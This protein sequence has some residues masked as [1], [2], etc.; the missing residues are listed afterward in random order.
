VEEDFIIAKSIIDRVFP[1]DFGIIDVGS[2][3]G[4]FVSFVLGMGSRKNAIMIEPI[5]EKAEIIRN[6]FPSA[7]VFQCAISTEEKKS[8]MFVTP[9]FP[10]CSALY[11]R[12]AFNEIEILNQREKI[13][14]SLRRLESILDESE[15]DQS[16]SSSWYLKIDTEGFELETFSSI[17]RYANHEKI[18]A[19]QFEYGGCWKERGIK[20]SDMLQL[21]ETSGFIAYRALIRENSLY[22]LKVENKDD[23]YEHTNIY[24]MRKNLVEDQRN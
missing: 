12:Q 20:I 9:N 3:E 2:H 24:F 14:V 17:G 16:P 19:G 4:D 15:F 22:F 11:D 6:R 8:D 21:L 5:P 23:D 1:K 10:K 13:E 18:L 7:K